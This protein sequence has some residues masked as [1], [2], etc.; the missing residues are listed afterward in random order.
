MASDT[1]LWKD[2]KYIDEEGI[3]NFCKNTFLLIYAGNNGA[4]T[5]ASH[6]L[7]LKPVQEV[8]IHSVQICS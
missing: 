5:L 2:Y 7:H 4:K 6:L 3:N 1:S 8:V